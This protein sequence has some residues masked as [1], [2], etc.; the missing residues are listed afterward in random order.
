[1]SN[2]NVYLVFRMSVKHED[3]CMFD[4]VKDIVTKLDYHSSSTRSIQTVSNSISSILSFE[5]VG[6]L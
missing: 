5:T 6:S 3:W 2:L 1:M 4:S